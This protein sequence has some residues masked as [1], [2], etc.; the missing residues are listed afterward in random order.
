MIPKSMGVSSQSVGRNRCHNFSFFFQSTHHVAIQRHVCR[1][2]KFSLSFPTFV[3]HGEP[4]KSLPHGRGRSSSEAYGL[5]KW[6][7]VLRWFVGLLGG[8]IFWRW[9]VWCWQ[10]GQKLYSWW[11]PM[12]L[13]PS[14]VLVTCGKQKSCQKLFQSRTC[15]C[16]E[17]VNTL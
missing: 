9:C 13:W 7:G 12:L 11:P 6:W 15:C 17:T 10:L 8:R 4:K 5:A 3:Y 16:K 14:S 2:K 1:V